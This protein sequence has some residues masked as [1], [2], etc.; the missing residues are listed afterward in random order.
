MTI[1]KIEN[2]DS[3]VKHKE[4]SAILAVDLDAYKQHMN[5]RKKQVSSEQ[6]IIELER[7]V[8]EL[9]KFI[10]QLNIQ[11]PSMLKE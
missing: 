3:I 11:N 8:A 1:L 5:R 6:K 7:R 9:E 4:S 10:R 2:N